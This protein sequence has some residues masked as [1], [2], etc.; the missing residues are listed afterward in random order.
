MVV[1]DSDNND[2]SKLI[3]EN[4]D[5]FA[6]KGIELK[7]CRGNEKNRGLTAAR[8]IG[9]AKSVGEI[10]FFMD[11]DVILDSKYVEEVM[12]T[13]DEYPRA[14]GVQG[15][16]VS[17][18]MTVK[19]LRTILLNSMGKVFCG[20]YLEKDKCSFGR[21]ASYPY[22]PDKIIQ[23]QWLHGSNMSFKKEILQSFQF[24]ENLKGTF[25]RRRCGFFLQNLQTLPKFL[26]YES[27]G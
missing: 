13:Y 18:G 2:T 12:K 9:A 23:C 15:Y 24:D 27:T 6:N 11:D 8:N 3:R 5:V 17:G 20:D 7:Y 16:I 26:A 14:E 25:N 10:V 22:F 1:D 4:Y 21:G 19:N